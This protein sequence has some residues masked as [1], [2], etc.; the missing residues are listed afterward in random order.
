[1]K[2]SVKLLTLY[3]NRLPEGTE[4]NTCEL[5]VP[6][7]TP[8]EILLARFGIANDKTSVILVNGIV[9]GPGQLLKEGDVVCAFPAFA[10]G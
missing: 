4:G 1:M 5:Y 6:E 8:V 10:G 3:R 9:P 7:D 2:I